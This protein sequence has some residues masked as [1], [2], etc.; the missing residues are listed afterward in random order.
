MK[1]VPFS[2]I[3][4]QTGDFRDNIQSIKMK[5]RMAKKNKPSSQ[6]SMKRTPYS[7]P[8]ATEQDIQN[9]RNRLFLL[10]N[11]HG[12]DSQ[13]NK[14]KLAPLSNKIVIKKENLSP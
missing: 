1:S 4:P 8:L 6:Q 13:Q 3:I 14:I 9:I 10:K 11:K 2:N 12:K 5:A 7:E